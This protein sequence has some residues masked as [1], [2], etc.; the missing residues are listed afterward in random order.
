MLLY[1][2]FSACLLTAIENFILGPIVYRLN[3]SHLT[4]RW[5]V[6]CL[7]VGIWSLG[8]GMVIITSNSAIALKW[9]KFYYCG[10]ILIPV[11][12]L[13]FALALIN[14]VKE[15]RK[16]VNIGYFISVIFLLTNFFGGVVSS[17][18]PKFI[19]LNTSVPGVVF[20]LLL[21]YFAVYV[22]YGVYLEIKEMLSSK[23]YERAKLMYIVVAS[24]I[25]F[26]GGGTGFLIVYGIGP[27]ASI[28]M[29][30]V[31]LYP[32]IVAYSVATVH[33]MDIEIFMHRTTRALIGI[34]LFSSV[35]YL[36][37]FFSKGS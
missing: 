26:I 1:I 29:C 35:L 4:R 19:F 11:T 36:T 34:I 24:F 37:F 12:Y 27:L 18:S 7:S 22:G 2:F 23:G 20:P 15:K 25:G 21:S 6:L 9:A 28:G 14:K 17:V 32:L 13:H 5:F 31:W 10:V 33:L 30:L 8:F 3:K 16:I